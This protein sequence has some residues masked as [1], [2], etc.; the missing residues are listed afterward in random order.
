MQVAVDIG[1]E[2]LF[3]SLCTSFLMSVV[4][5]SFIVAIYTYLP[6]FTQKFK[7]IATIIRRSRQINK[8][9]IMLRHVEL[10]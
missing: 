4:I 10:K 6:L 8:R 2:V 7:K 1:S 9:G 5:G 3:L